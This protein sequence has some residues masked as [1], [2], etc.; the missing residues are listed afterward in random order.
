MVQWRV[1]WQTT[2]SKEGLDVGEANESMWWARVRYGE[3]QE[4]RLA[5]GARSAHDGTK[6]WSIIK[7]YQVSSVSLERRLM[8]GAVEQGIISL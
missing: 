3:A 4:L 8:S 6:T 2:T 5:A 1:S 7:H